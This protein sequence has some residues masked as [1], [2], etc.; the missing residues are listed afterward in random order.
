MTSASQHCLGSRF[1]RAASAPIVCVN[2]RVHVTRGGQNRKFYYASGLPLAGS[3]ALGR[4][5]YFT[6]LYEASLQDQFLKAGL[7]NKNKAKLVH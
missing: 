7:I 6:E 1:S 5:L 3:L 4:W 2:C